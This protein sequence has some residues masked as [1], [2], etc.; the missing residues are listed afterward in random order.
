MHLA[1]FFFNFAISPG[2]F[3]YQHVLVY[4]LCQG[5][6]SQRRGRGGLG[7]AKGVRSLGEG[8]TDALRDR[9]E[10]ARRA[11]PVGTAPLLSHLLLT[12]VHKG[13]LISPVFRRPGSQDVGQLGPRSTRGF[14]DPVQASSPAP[15]MW[16][17]GGAP[18][19][20][21]QP[22][23]PSLHCSQSQVEL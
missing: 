3:P 10:A 15:G 16:A 18:L 6:G 1:F 13:A 11:M 19:P 5:R 17:S 4:L 8:V 22:P 2:A 23:L 12:T 9:E 7:W 21:P 14:P 20:S